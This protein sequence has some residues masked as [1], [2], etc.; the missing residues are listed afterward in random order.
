MTSTAAV[1][2]DKYESDRRFQVWRYQVGHS[3]LLLRSVKDAS[4]DSRID[5]LFKAVDRID[6][7][8]S[9]DGLNI[10]RQGRDFALSGQGWVGRVTAG[11]CVQAEDEGEYFDPSPFETSF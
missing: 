3:Q 6:L 2:V 9:F 8:T 11:V 1:P 5:L 4:H 10:L 7:P